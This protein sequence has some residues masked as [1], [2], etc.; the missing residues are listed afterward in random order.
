MDM[1]SKLSNPLE[2]ARNVH[3]LSSIDTLRQASKS[4]DKG[5]LVEAAK[6]FEGIFVQ[7]ML[8]SM[9]KAQAVLSDKDSPFNSQQVSFYRDMHDKQLATELSTN[10]SLGLADIII[11]Q[12]GGA[13]GFMPAEALRN[14]GNLPNIPIKQAGFD[15]PEQF[16]QRL[17][18]VAQQA[19][20]ALNIAPEALIAQAALET[21]WGQYVMHQ[22]QA[23]AHNLFG[24]K[25]DERWQGQSINVPTLEYDQGIA[26]QEHAQF[27]KYASYT[28]S[29]QDY[30]AFM[31][32]NE[33]Y[34]QALTQTDSPA[35]YFHE[36]QRAGYATDPQ[37]ADKILRIMQSDVLTS[38]VSAID[39][40][41]QNLQTEAQHQPLDSRIGE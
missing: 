40:P 32:S 26:K 12:F 23:N 25:A 9:R 34:S 17:Y 22:G 36:L 5:A 7:M 41:A 37:Y 8:K 39:N 2:M 14:D 30:V 1:Q 29:M 38:T 3:D 10:S 21:G 6:Q 28:D 19:A 15:S 24:I 27:R 16:I 31:Q 33:R 18:P 11:Q 20:S 4:G 35:Q 13:E